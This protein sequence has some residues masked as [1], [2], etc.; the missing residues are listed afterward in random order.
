LDGNTTLFF[1]FM[2][3]ASSAA[4]NPARTQEQEYAL[5]RKLVEDGATLEEIRSQVFGRTVRLS[6][7]WALRHKPFRQKYVEHKEVIW[8]WA[9]AAPKSA[10]WVNARYPGAY[11]KP[12]GK[13]WTGFQRQEVVVF[14]NMVRSNSI[15]PGDFNRIF[16]KYTFD[17]ETRHSRV[18]VVATKMII[19]ST[20]RPEEV[21][22][23]WDAID[24]TMALRR[25]SSIIHA[26]E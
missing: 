8:V 26:E 23:T 21:F 4:A 17:A 9:S 24:L 5:M 13:W 22:R 11:V 1:V 25:I 6:A 20:R 2:D 15:L 18:A 14:R 7:A 16:D 10:A 12:S 19:T 3:A